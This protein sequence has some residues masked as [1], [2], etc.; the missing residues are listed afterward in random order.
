MF[1]LAFSETKRLF[2]IVLLAAK[3]TSTQQ[4]FCSYKRNAKLFDMLRR[5]FLAGN[6]LHE[7]QT[8]GVWLWVSKKTHCN[9]RQ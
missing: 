3:G 7:L 2:K 9:F 4:M 1:G 6:Q 5:A 8:H